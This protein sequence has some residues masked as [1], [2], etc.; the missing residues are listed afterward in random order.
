ML[1]N[2]DYMTARD[3]LLDVA[4]PVD[5]Q[6]LPLSAC[7]GR[8]LAESVTAAENVPPFDRSP[9]DGYAFRSEDTDGTSRESPVTL[10][11]IEEVPAGAVPT[12]GCTKNTAVKILTG[13]PIPE[14]ADAVINYE[15]TE[16]TESAV[17]IFAPIKSGENIVRAGEDVRKGDV[18]VRAGQVIDPG[19]AGTLAAQGIARPTVYRRPR[20]GV[21]STGNEVAE[22]GAPL[23]P[24][25]IYNSNRYTL[26]AA[27]WEIGCESVYLGLAGDSPEAIRELIGKG[28]ADCDAVVTTGGVS[29][30]DYDFTPDAMERAGVNILFRGVQMKP[31]MACAYGEKGGKLVCGLSGNPASSLS[32]FYLVAVP[33]LKKLAGRSDCVP[34]EIPVTL[35][36]DFKKKS[37]T[38]RLL[39]GRLD[40]SDGSVRLITPRD[41]GNVVISSAIGCDGMAVVPAGTGPI[42]A[43]TKLKGFKL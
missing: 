4:R 10:R 33:A 36:K 39:R 11:V 12:K 37:P 2:P 1:K 22:I 3:L 14:G 26:S 27:L 7:F 17:T 28:L 5:T 29:V 32:N 15:R 6:E 18:L 9:Y 8:V 23:A 42:A 31:G 41:Q 40:L 19:T 20:V 16:F 13:A 30:G 43:G 35:A 34:E 25:K 38:T 24:G 21:I